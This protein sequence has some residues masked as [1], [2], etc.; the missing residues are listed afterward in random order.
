[1]LRR[2]PKATARV[3]AAAATPDN[4]GV[5]VVPAVMEAP[6]GPGP[7]SKQLSRSNGTTHAHCPC[8]TTSGAQHAPDSS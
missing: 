5:Q 6:P 2:C 3:A 8:P 7:S 1:M 4:Y